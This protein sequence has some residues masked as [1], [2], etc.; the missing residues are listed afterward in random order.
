MNKKHFYA[1][2]LEGKPPDKW[3]PLDKHLKNVAEK[4]AQFAKP[5]GGEQWAYLAGLWHDLGKY[6]DAFQ[7][8]LLIENGYANHNGINFARVI[9]SEAGGH[10]SSL[11]GWRGIDRILSWL[12]MG[13]HAGLSDFSPDRIGGKALSPKM[14]DPQKSE[15]ILVN[16]PP[17]ILD[18]KPPASAFPKGIDPAFFIRML[19]SCIVDSDFLDTEEI[20]NKVAGKIRKQEGV[21]LETLKKKLNKYM[22]KIIE[23]AEPSPVNK[24]RKEV[25]NYCVE[26]AEEKPQ[27]FSLTVPTGGGKTLASLAFA[28]HHASKYEKKRIIYV[29]PYISII[30][31]TAD[32]FRN[33]SGFSESVLEHHCNV[34][35]DNDRA[36]TLKMRLAAENWDMP[37]VVTT[38]VQF[39]ESLYASRTSMCRKLHNIVNSVIIFDEI[40]C[41][42]PE[43]LRPIVFAIRELYEHYNVTPLLCTATQP[44]LTRTE[45]FDFKFREG[46]SEVREIVP[47]PQ[48][49]ADALNRVEIKLMRKK[50]TVVSLNEVA[51]AIIS[52]KKAVLCIVNTKKDCRELARLLPKHNVVHL[53]TN[54]CAQHR[55]DKLRRIRMA[56]SGREDILVISTSLVEAGVDLDFPVVYRALAGL[57]SIAQAAGRCNRE[58]KLTSGKTVIFIPEEQPSYIVQPAGITKEFL[59]ENDL[60]D[61]FS[62]A[63]YEKY[64]KQRFWQLGEDSLDRKNILRYFSERMNYYFRTAAEEFNLIGTKWQVPVIVP[65]GRAQE[66]IN[67][68]IDEPWNQRQLLRQLNRF[69]VNI[70]NRCFRELSLTECVREI[71]QVPGVFVLEQI[72][73]DD[74]FGFV[75]PDDM[76]ISDPNNFFC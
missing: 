53:S 64:F 61:I 35:Y 26:C 41:V 49:M 63:H 16:I 46:F 55:L 47:E 42:P 10:L 11:K 76:Q 9:H 54:M 24:V 21:P 52:E 57:D 34:S 4:A 3:Q 66:L 48:K 73:Y 2:S 23:R 17:E 7:A 1:H 62:P 72:L 29:I 40:Q 68:L 15:H 18:Q 28:L 75:L 74:F 19:F 45:N 58:G 51:E 20:M 43:Y 32:V 70:A 12:I 5:F 38:A 13:H 14:S 22:R 36:E 39:F 59:A 44:V 27:V 50:E 65:Y 30:E 56:L 25:L 31:Q 69:I 71:K 6:S 37:V 33:I 8:K 60:S 67:R